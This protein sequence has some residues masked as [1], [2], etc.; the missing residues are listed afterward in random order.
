MTYQTTAKEIRKTSK[1]NTT[2]A[3]LHGKMDT[4]LSFEEP[5]ASTYGKYG[6]NFDTYHIHGLTICTGNRGM[7]GREMN[8]VT[9]FEL[10]ARQVMFTAL[11]I[12]EKREKITA[13][14][15]EL[16]KLNGGD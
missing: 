1:P 2:F 15:E 4:L 14:L 6:W 5:T 9:D 3:V 8:A 11:T 12:D 13:L 10:K 7:I 16:C